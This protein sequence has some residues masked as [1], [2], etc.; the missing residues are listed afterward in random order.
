MKQSRYFI[1]LLFIISFADISCSTHDDEIKAI[2]DEADTVWMPQIIYDT[3]YKDSIVHDTI[4]KDSLVHDTVFI[5]SLIHD[6]IVIDNYVTDTII[7]DSIIHDTIIIEHGLDKIRVAQWNVGHF[8]LGK[9]YD[10]KI[11]HDRF[12]TMQKKWAEA[13]KEINADVFCCC[14]YNTNFVNAD[15]DHDAVTAREAIFPQYQFAYIGSKPYAKS[16]MQ[17]AIFS[18]LP[19]KNIKQKVYKHTVQVGRYFQ[20]GDLSINGKVVKVV[21][22]H[23][24]FNQGENGAA[25]RV[26]QIHELV[27][28]FASDPYV[29]ICADWNASISNYDILTD[30]G[31]SMANHGSIGDVK[32]YPAGNNPLWVL[33]NIVCKGFDISGIEFVNDPTLT[34]HMAIYAD[35]TITEP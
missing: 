19:I 30:G 2:V 18:H 4:I 6:T 23:L 34:D 1:F 15:Q 7:K 28:F 10:T 11:T 20:Y 32:T 24:D 5:D 33:D 17:T 14:E 9:T 25:Y 13:I 27:D 26:D 16:Y 8:A 35:F 12:E 22:T 3:I 29:I 31:Y 21:A